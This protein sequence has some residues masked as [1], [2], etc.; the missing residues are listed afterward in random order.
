MLKR[1]VGI[2]VSVILIMSIMLYATAEGRTEGF[3]V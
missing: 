2:I 1:G 3:A